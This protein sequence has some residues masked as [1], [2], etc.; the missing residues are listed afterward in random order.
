MV[1][2]AVMTASCGAASR[3]PADGERGPGVR[4]GGIPS[5]VAQITFK[6]EP[7]PPKMGENAFEAMVMA[8][9]QPVTD[10]EVAVEFFMA[11][12]PTMNMAGDAEQPSR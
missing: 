2:V 5:G 7:D 12:M 4:A 8:N 10:A 1:A 9:G 6:S 3:P 11:A